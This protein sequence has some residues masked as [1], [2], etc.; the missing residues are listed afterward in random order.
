M[1][2]Y[3][4]GALLVCLA[5]MST[6]A[7]VSLPHVLSDNMLVQR[8]ALV[9]IWGNADP[10][11][12]VHVIANG[13]N[14][15]E[16]ADEDGRWSVSLS[17]LPAGGPYEIEVQGEGNQIVLHNVM[18]G[19]LWICS[20]QSNMETPISRVAENFPQEL[21]TSANAN[22]RL[23][24]APCSYNFKAPQ[25]DYPS[26][27]WQQAAPD[28]LQNFSATGYFFARYLEEETGVPVG[29]INVSNGGSPIAAWLSESSLAKFPDFLEE[30]T[31]WKSD[32]LI[33]E[34]EA[35]NCEINA[36]WY[37]E[38]NRKDPG[39]KPGAEWFRNDAST[40]GWKAIS[41]PSSFEEQG[42][43]GNGTIWLRKE[44]NVPADMAA[45]AGLLRLGNIVQ[46]DTAWING[47]QV[48]NTTYEYP[49]RRYP[50]PA[51]VL[52]EGRNVVTIRVTCN[53]G[54]GASFV[55]DKPYQIEAAGQVVDLKGSWNAM[56]GAETGPIEPTV[57]VRWK[58][59]GLHNGMYG[60]ISRLHVKGV[61][62]YQGES[63]T[64]QPKRYGELLQA[65]VADWRSMWGDVPVLIQ[66][67]PNFM[68]PSTGPMESN[69]AQM[70]ETQRVA[71]E[72]IPNTALS[73]AIDL[74][75]WNDIHPWNKKEVG[76]RL[77][78]A[79]LNL[80]YGQSIVASGPSLSG[81]CVCK[82]KVVVS[83]TNVGGGLVALGGEPLE[84]FTLAGA[85]GVFHAAKARICGDTVVV[86]SDAVPEPVQVRYAWANNP[87]GANLYNAEGLPASPFEGR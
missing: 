6:L 62:W 38:L 12:E 30:A 81:L 53:S 68:E 37:G 87:Q 69:W 60:P 7:N 14:L 56:R 27:K 35:R 54:S 40:Q 42:L 13:Q 74:G 15:T 28:T 63:D 19:D 76:Y 44:V 70:R 34:T 66:Q 21:A 36:Q 4:L 84:Q 39:L 67:L 46:A 61:V 59:L 8:E 45:Q 26:G 73:V 5:P 41:I 11:E 18:S 57:F 48:G 50:I 23:F 25:E 2:H 49:P 9:P 20:G 43:G 82:D 47:Q 78:L 52:K 31:R 65:L 55:L 80:A 22:I 10:K 51:G 75:E 1:R 29:I 86:W 77:S 16:C 17:A 32:A 71:S 24:T 58:P 72:E 83:F 79:A 64:W 33:E 85:D 3:P